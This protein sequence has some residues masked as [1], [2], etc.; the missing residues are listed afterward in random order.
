MLKKAIESY[1]TLRKKWRSPVDPHAED[2]DTS[3]TSCSDWFPCVSEA[4]VFQSL[5]HGVIS[6]P[7]IG[8][9][10]ETDVKFARSRDL[11]E[12]NRLPESRLPAPDSFTHNQFSSYSES[13][14]ECMP[15]REGRSCQLTSQIGKSERE[16]LS[17]STHAGVFA[18]TARI[19]VVSSLSLIGD[20]VERQRCG[21]SPQ[22]A[23]KQPL[24]RLPIRTRQ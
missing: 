11:C 24:R 13:P 12:G 5:D 15:F 7:M 22:I 16:T 19:R 21:V 2:L 9:P 17:V 14:S 8:N 1:G 20:A 6:D 10:T 4:C 3:S 18:V 23:D